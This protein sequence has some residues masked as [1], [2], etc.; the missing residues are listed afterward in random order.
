MCSVGMRAAGRQRCHQLIAKVFDPLLGGA[1]CQA[2]YPCYCLLSSRSS[3]LR[4]YYHCYFIS[5]EIEKPKHR[6]TFDNKDVTVIAQSG[7][8]IQT[9]AVIPEYVL[10]I[11]ILCSPLQS[12]GLDI[13]SIRVP[14][15]AVEQ[16]NKRRQM[17][18]CSLLNEPGFSLS[19]HN[20]K[21]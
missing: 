15:Q 19:F 8:G 11:T 12:S 20:S 13:Q 4:C 10:R 5:E 6:K 7:A 1:Q 21:T 16:V 18:S 2:F 17:K 3:L 14:C 9:Q